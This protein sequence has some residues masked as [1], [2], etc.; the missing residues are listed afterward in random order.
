MSKRRDGVRTIE[1][2]EKAP[3]FTLHDSAGNE[4]SLAEELRKGPVV[5]AFFKISCPVCQFTFPFLERLHKAFGNSAATFLAVSQ[6][7]A[8][9]TR[10]FC[11]E[12][13]ITFPALIDG[14]PYAISSAYGITNVPSVF[15]IAPDGTVKLTSI[16]FDKAKLEAMAAALAAATKRPASALFRPGEVVPSYKP[17]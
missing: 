1:E 6:D 10:E 9:D 4:Y 12:Y 2:K 7:D 15:L 17:G 5:A 11:N 3:Q 13:G 8:Q 16:G 14:E